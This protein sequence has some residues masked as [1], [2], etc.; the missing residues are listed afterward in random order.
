MKPVLALDVYGTL[1][2][3]LH[4]S[5]TLV[6]H[7]GS[8]ASAMAETWRAKQLEYSFRRALMGDYAP[9][10]VVT[11]DALEYASLVHGV[12]L[13][14]V[15]KRHLLSVYLRLDAFVD[16]SP[17][18]AALTEAGIPLHAFTNGVAT[19][20]ASLLGHA[21]IAAAISSIVSVDE[22]QSFKPDPQVYAHFNAIADV[23]PEATW[24]VSANPFDIAGANKAGWNTI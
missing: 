5:E 24:L 9:F 23:Q 13:T 18:L 19:D 6:D 12:P 15:T 17:A 21:G 8:A 4:V 2:D 7:A 10:S 1:I 20:V 11:A 16:V 3:P 14:P 22:V